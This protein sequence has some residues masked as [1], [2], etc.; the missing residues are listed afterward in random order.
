MSE[1]APDDGPDQTVQFRTQLAQLPQMGG[2][3]TLQNR[4][5]PGS[6]THLHP[7]PVE[8]GG[9]PPEQSPPGEPVHQ[10]HGAVMAQLQPLREL[11]DGSLVAP[12]K[13]LDGQQRLVLLRGEPGAARGVLAEDQEAAQRM[14]QRGQQLVVGL[15]DP[16]TGHGEGK[17]GFYV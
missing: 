10:P 15:G 3:Q 7:A 8:A 2:R 4:L 6:K 5:P 12:G 17:G 16:A 9:H 11:A 13:T 14:A 1:L